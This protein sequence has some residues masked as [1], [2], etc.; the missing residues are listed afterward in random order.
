MLFSSL[1][2]R[3]ALIVC[4]LGKSAVNHDTEEL[5]ED[6]SPN[7]DRRYRSLLRSAEGDLYRHLSDPDSFPIDDGDQEMM[8]IWSPRTGEEIRQE[9]K[10][11]IKEH[12]Q[13]ANELRSLAKAEQDADRRAT[14]ER[15]AQLNEDLAQT[16]EVVAGEALEDVLSPHNKRMSCVECIAKLN[17]ERRE[18]EARR[19]RVSDQERR[20]IDGRLR[21]LADQLRHL[22]EEN[23]RL[24]L[25]QHEATLRYWGELRHLDEAVRLVVE[26]DGR[27]KFNALVPDIRT[28]LCTQWHA[29]EQVKKYEDEAAL[30]MA[31]GDVLMTLSATLPVATLAVLVVKIGVK[32]FCNCPA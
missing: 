5:V 23:D 21:T 4:E 30:M 8:S 14:L 13:A 22:D 9:R 31:I 27:A 7:P 2:S 11:R 18:L 26:A 10:S 32:K 29:C 12:R 19:Y 16:L 15:T 24:R 1:A 25:E 28:R 6:P 3:V 20:A 17:E